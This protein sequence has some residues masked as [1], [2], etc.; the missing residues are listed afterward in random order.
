MKKKLVI[1]IAV[2]IL[3]YVGVF[4]VKKHKTA[5]NV[6]PSEQ[7]FDQHET[8]TDLTKLEMVSAGS[9]TGS[10]SSGGHTR[11][12]TIHI[13]KEYTTTQKYALVFL[14][15]GGSGNGKIP[16]TLIGGAS[17]LKD[18]GMEVKADSSGF[19][20][21]AP[22]AL[23]GNWNDGR[24]TTNTEKEGIDDVQFVRDM[25]TALEKKYAI[26][27]KKIY[28]AGISNGGMF[29]HRLACEAPDIIAAIGPVSSA[30]PKPIMSTCTSKVA[31]V[32]IQGTE[33]P[34]VS[35]DGSV[36]EKMKRISGNG[37]AVAGAIETMNLWATNN[38]CSLTPTI[39][40]LP[41]IVS[42]G[43]SVQ[44]YSFSGCS[45]SGAVSYYVINGMG[46]AWP[47]G[48]M[49]AKK[50]M[51]QVISGPTSGN[52]NTPDVLWEFFSAHPHL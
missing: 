46:H 6:L 45:T 35:F 8:L 48:M 28:A 31:M 32:G 37:G 50:Q 36:S 38:Q 1:I 17:F 15:H 51:V 2:V 30:I 39:T 52:L 34:F 25:L 10:V 4:L 3:V 33:D 7:I 23:E 16:T 40:A 20:V 14:F 9:Y 24:G 47:G 26:D 19:I 43:T 41:V 21:V 18:S 27:P 42:D 44:K 12:Y 22:D 5:Q 29:S 49:S 13:P 11:S